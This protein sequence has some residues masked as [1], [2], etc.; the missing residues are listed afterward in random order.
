MKLGVGISLLAF[1]LASSGPVV[2]IRL[3]WPVMDASLWVSDN[4]SDH[5]FYACSMMSMGCYSLYLPCE[6]CVKDLRRM[7]VCMVMVWS[8]M[9]WW[10]PATQGVKRLVLSFSTIVGLWKFL[11]R[12]G[13]VWVSDGIADHMLICDVILHTYMMSRNHTAFSFQVFPLS[14]LFCGFQSAFLPLPGQECVYSPVIDHVLYA[15]ATL[16]GD[17]W[18]LLPLISCLISLFLWF[19]GWFLGEGHSMMSRP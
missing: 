18:S 14:S 10:M 7:W 9:S 2:V 4:S 3:F 16:S 8:E 5:V 13:Q 19:G 15:C 1:I 11:V 17:L 12:F 6:A